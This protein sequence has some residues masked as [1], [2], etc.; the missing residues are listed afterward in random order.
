MT[1]IKISL[2]N[3]WRRF[4]TWSSVRFSTAFAMLTVG[5]A[6]LLPTIAAHWPQLLPVLVHW[7]PS[8]DQSLWPALGALVMILARVTSIQKVNP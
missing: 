5:L 6:H 8:A 4:Y 1:H 7:F 2:V 3:D